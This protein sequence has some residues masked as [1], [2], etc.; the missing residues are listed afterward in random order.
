MI[1]GFE[2]MSCGSIY[3]GIWG[4]AVSVKDKNMYVPS[5]DWAIIQMDTFRNYLETPR[6]KRN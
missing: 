2:N 4:K 1:T 3:M 5:K 6:R